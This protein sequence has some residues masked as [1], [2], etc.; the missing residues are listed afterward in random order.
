MY[1]MSRYLLFMEG[2]H[3]YNHQLCRK[4]SALNIIELIARC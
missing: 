2:A 1:I 3:T 4:I